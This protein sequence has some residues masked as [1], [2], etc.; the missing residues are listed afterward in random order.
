[1]HPQHTFRD[2]KWSPQHHAED[3]S[4]SPCRITFGRVTYGG[5][6]YYPHPETKL[7]HHHDASTLEVIA[8]YVEGL[9][10]GV[11]VE[12]EIDTSEIAL[13]GNR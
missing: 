10:Y 7:G 5:W 4:F 12:L 1:V 3:F 2:V 8:P 11:E 6:I 9:R 13:S